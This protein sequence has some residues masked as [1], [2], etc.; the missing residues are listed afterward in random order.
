MKVWTMRSVALVK[1]LT[2]YI[3]IIQN[4]MNRKLSQITTA[5]LCILVQ[6][7]PEKKKQVSNLKII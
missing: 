3:F 1:N 5:N 6:T 4:T 7:K 2:W